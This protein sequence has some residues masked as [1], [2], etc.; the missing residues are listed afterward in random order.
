MAQPQQ[1]QPS[2]FWC[3]TET[4][5]FQIVKVTAE[6]NGIHTVEPIEGSLFPKEKQVRV[7]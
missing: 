7:L 6:N 3:N 5:G 2:L 1:E 4:G